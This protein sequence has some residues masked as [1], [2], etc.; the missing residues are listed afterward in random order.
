VLYNNCQ[1]KHVTSF[2]TGAK[3]K[4]VL[5]QDGFEQLLAAAFVLQQHSDTLRASDPNADPLSVLS[6]IT[7]IDSTAAD[8][9]KRPVLDDP[10]PPTREILQLHELPRCTACGRQFGTAEEFCGGCGRRRATESSPEDLQAKWASL[11]YM[12]QAKQAP[13][14]GAPSISAG[15]EIQPL[16]PMAARDFAKEETQSQTTELPV[17]GATYE[18]TEAEINFPKPEEQSWTSETPRETK[19]LDVS[20]EPAPPAEQEE[21]FKVLP[22]FPVLEIKEDPTIGGAFYHQ[23]EEASEPAEFESASGEKWRV[24]GEAEVDSQNEST[25][26]LWRRLNAGDQGPVIEVQ[27]ESPEVEYSE[28][29]PPEESETSRLQ[30]SWAALRSGGTRTVGLAACALMLLVALWAF[31]PNPSTQSPHSRLRSLL[32]QLGLAQ[33]SGQNAYSGNPNTRVWVDVHTALYYC[34]GS[35]LYGKTPGG[36]FSKQRAAQEDQLEPSTSVP[37]D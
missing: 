4:P 5:D 34:P 29:A 25:Q 31:R 1:R 24:S 18:K 12:S 30:G 17:Q 11:W 33:S 36:H 21:N 19:E 9:A 7:V 14:G 13:S 10:L 2:S 8:Q 22:P 23:V 16:E 28:F 27:V 37:C 32:V 35:E 6:K 26:E 3:H 20:G 15:P